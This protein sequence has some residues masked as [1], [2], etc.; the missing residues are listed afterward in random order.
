MPLVDRNI[1]RLG[2]YELIYT[3]LPV[4]VPLNEC[5]ELAKLYGTANSGSFING[6]L[7]AVANDRDKKSPA[8]DPTE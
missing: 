8:Q 5:V 7:S 4:G 1:L 3:D 2:T 6:V